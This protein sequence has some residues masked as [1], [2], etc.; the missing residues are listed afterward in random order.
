ML[1]VIQRFGKLSSRHLLVEC[2]EVGHFW[3]PCIG[4]SV[5]GEKDLMVLIGGSEERT[6]I[7]WEKSMWMR[8]RGDEFF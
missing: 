3:K 7:Q 6:A 5:G 1:K 2:A 8:K 4:Q